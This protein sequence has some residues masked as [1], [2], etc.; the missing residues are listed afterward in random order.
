MNSTDLNT[1]EVMSVLTTLRAAL[2]RHEKASRAVAEADGKA[3]YQQ[4]WEE[5]ESF[6]YLQSARDDL[7]E[8][9]TGKRK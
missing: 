4:S 2:K 6:R 8:L 1:T 5:K 7:E 3:T 9:L